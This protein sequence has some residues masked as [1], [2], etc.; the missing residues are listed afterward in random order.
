MTVTI[1]P[2]LDQPEQVGILFAEYTQ[3]LIDGDAT[4]ARYLQM[5]HYDEEL[6][7][8]AAKYGPPDGRLYL[9]YDDG[10]PAGCI[11][12]KRHDDACGELKRL[13]VRPAYRGRHIGE[14]LL[15]QIVADATNIGYRA[16]V[17]DTLP[18]L[19]EALRLYEKFGFY[20]TTAYNDSPMSNSIFL[21][22][23]L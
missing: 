4:F 3:M 19:R 21:R 5:Q 13:Y 23:D 8:L 1:I 10:Q 22:L 17:L 20:E 15:R 2:A 14:R 11:A 12:L 7:Q 9:A 16:I 18:F 6:R